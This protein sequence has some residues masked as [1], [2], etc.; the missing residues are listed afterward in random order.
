[1]TVIDAHP[2]AS[3]GAAAERISPP[4][5]VHATRSQRGGRRPGCRLWT[6]PGPA[7]PGGHP[8][9]SPASARSSGTAQPKS[10]RPWNCRS[11]P[12]G[13]PINSDVDAERVTTVQF[14]R[15][16]R[17]DRQGRVT[18][19]SAAELHDD[20]VELRELLGRRLDHCSGRPAPVPSSWSAAYRM[21]GPRV[22]A[23]SVRLGLR[24]G[25][26]RAGPSCRVSPAGWR[27]GVRR[28]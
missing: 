18:A 14:D 19:G 13:V 12:A 2:L 20:V 11:T 21:E 16:G 4:S 9:L 22:T 27:G 10:G 6:C 26:A 28:S 25:A 24:I 23:R 1:M 5:S 7:S 17:R 15:H 3:A 8:A